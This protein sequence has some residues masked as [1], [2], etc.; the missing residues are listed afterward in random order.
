MISIFKKTVFAIVT[1]C[2][3][4]WDERLQVRQLSSRGSTTGL[5]IAQGTL[6]S[7][8]KKHPEVQISLSGGGSGEGIKALMNKTADIATTSSREI[9]KEEVELAK[10][11]ML[12][13]LPMWW[14]MTLLFRL[15]I[16]KTE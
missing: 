8:M 6:E 5:P 16:P 9:K 4:E 10:T 15:C 7:F 12:I 3:D 14:Q 11:K 2:A 13:L 1:F